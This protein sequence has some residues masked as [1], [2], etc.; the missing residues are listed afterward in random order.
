MFK[1]YAISGL[2]KNI[3]LVFLVW[4]FT[5][6]WISYISINV[7]PIWGDRFPYVSEYL[8]STGLPYWIWQW[9]NFDGIHYLSI[10]YTLYDAVY[11][12]AFFPLFPFLIR[13]IG[14]LIASN[15]YLVIGLVLSNVFFLLSL[16]V[17]SKVMQQEKFTNAHILW[18]IVFLLLFPTSFYFVS[19]Y[20]ES[21]FLL[22]VLIFTYLVNQNKW[23]YAGIAGM[24]ASATKLVG[25]FLMIFVLYQ[26][27]VYK[28]K[29]QKIRIAMFFSLCMIPIGLF[30]YMYYLDSRFGDYLMFWHSQPVFGAE[31]LGSGFVLPPQVLYRY[32]KILIS[33]PINS[34]AFYI[35]FQEAFS[36]IGALILLIFGYL[37]KVKYQY[38]IFSL[39]IIILPSLTG[40]FSSM[41]RYVLSAYPLFMILGLIKSTKTKIVLLVIFT[42]LLTINA[43]LFL[44]GYW[45]A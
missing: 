42:L 24:F 21:L 23:L 7:I 15:A 30:C 1:R 29:G 12:Q 19:L 44:R 45:V 32:V 43:T 37:K 20:T 25:L 41:P 26:M 9:A 40:T 18:S 36:F 39:F 13:I 34:W 35:A 17:F 3:I 38:L 33:V 22:L 8:T 16:I 2:T 11:T 4:R 14:Q 5:L 31:R 10:S 6:L 28:I 27:I